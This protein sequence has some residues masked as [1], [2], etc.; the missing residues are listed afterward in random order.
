MWPSIQPDAAGRCEALVPGTQRQLPQSLDAL[1]QDPVAFRHWYDLVLPRVYRYLLARAGDPSLAEEL[2]QQTF[3][4]AVR[5]RRTFDGRADVVT[6]LCAIG[7]NKLVDHY[8]R[9]GRE[10][11]RHERLRVL[12]DGP[13]HEAAF[14][15]RD[16]IRRALDELPS[17][18][19]LALMFRYLDQMPVREVANQ[20]RRSEKATES[21]LSRAR[22]SFR[23]AYGGPIR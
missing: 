4:E 12:E 5:N 3:V 6:W 23:L 14:D 17:D 20:L 1:V 13:D 11:D 8:R 19:R 16:A 22:V 9:A 10:A 7:R 2:T 18:Q 15:E 21:L